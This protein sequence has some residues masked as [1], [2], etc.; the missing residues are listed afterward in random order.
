MEQGLIGHDKWSEWALRITKNTAEELEAGKER[1]WSENNR[2][3]NGDKNNN[4]KSNGDVQV[5]DINLT[6][7]VEWNI[8]GSKEPLLYSDS[9]QYSQVILSGF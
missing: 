6:K 3:K 5:G 9:E 7:G 8:A 4:Q 2:K 1:N